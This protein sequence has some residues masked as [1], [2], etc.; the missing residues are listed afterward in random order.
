MI[1]IVK[2]NDF[3]AHFSSGQRKQEKEEWIILCYNC[4]LL[5]MVSDESL[6]NLMSLNVYFPYYFWAPV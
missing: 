5:I 6:C 3:C 2:Q 4:L 1:V